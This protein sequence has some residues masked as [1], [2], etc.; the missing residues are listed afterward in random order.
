[1]YIQACKIKLTQRN[2]PP[3]LLNAG[4]VPRVQVAPAQLG[5]YFL[6]VQLYE[7]LE[8]AF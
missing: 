8:F 3:A 2:E 6:Y 5:P 7:W 1:M 4:L